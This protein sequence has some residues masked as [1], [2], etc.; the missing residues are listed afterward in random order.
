MT[1]WSPDGFSRDMNEPLRRLCSALVGLP[2]THIWQGHGTALFLEFGD[3]AES[4]RSDGTVGNPKG[5][6]S[7]D[8]QFDWRV[9]SGHKIVCGSGGNSEIWDFHFK[10]MI[11]STT[12]D[13][14]VTGVIPELCL[15]LS[16]GYRVITC[17][18]D[19]DGPHWALMD[20]RQSGGICISATEGRIVVEDGLTPPSAS[21]TPNS[22]DE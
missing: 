18:L 1:D 15:D 16:N 6:I 10:S 11:G 4:Y 19:E 12:L 17:A 3:L 8:L 20:N 5:E 7:V 22:P 14:S 9:E 13:L 21:M 2:I